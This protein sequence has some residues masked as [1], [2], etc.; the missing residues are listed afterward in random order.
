MIAH[1]RPLKS[2]FRGR[3]SCKNILFDRITDA[4]DIRFEISSVRIR[5][6]SDGSCACFAT[7]KYSG[8]ALMYVDPDRLSTILRF[9]KENDSGILS[10]PYL[11]RSS[12]PSTNS[13]DAMNSSTS[14]HQFNILDG[15]EKEFMEIAQ[16][17]ANKLKDI[18][19]LLASSSSTTASHYKMF[20]F[21]I[22]KLLL[23]RFAVLCNLPQHECDYLFDVIERYIILN[24]TTREEETIPLAFPFQFGGDFT[25]HLDEESRILANEMRTYLLPPDN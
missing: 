5:V 24:N 9:C 3:E 23:R 22:N 8:T 17:A 12:P 1:D 11:G 19:P 7:Y 2:F 13:T 10:L 16:E 21:V 25:F 4:P 15:F 6:R 14:I 20:Q 18:I